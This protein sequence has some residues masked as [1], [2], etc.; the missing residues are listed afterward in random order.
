LLGVVE[1]RSLI[2]GDRVV[3]AKRLGDQK[4]EDLHN[5]VRAAAGAL[6]PRSAIAGR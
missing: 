5:V 1:D 6:T 2:A 4:P 3:G